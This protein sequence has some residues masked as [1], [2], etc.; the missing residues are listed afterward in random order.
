[1]RVESEVQLQDCTIATATPNRS[2]TCDPCC[3]W[4]QCQILN[5]LSKA[6]DR[7]CFLTKCSCQVLNSLS[8]SGSSS[9]WVLIEEVYTRH[10]EHVKHCQRDHLYTYITSHAVTSFLGKFCSLCQTNDDRNLDNLLITY[11]VKK[12]M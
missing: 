5:P 7:T 2:S 1:M 4:R 6:R 10:M 8:H 11:H 12:E 9:A 3:G